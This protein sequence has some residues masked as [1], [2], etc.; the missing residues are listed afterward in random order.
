MSVIETIPSV[1]TLEPRAQALG[2]PFIYPLRP[3]VGKN[4]GLPSRIAAAGNYLPRQNGIATF[5]TD[6]CDAISAECGA[7]G[8]ALRMYLQSY[9]S[10]C[11]LSC[12]DVGT[13]GQ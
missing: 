1:Q 13:P 7:A 5:T 8:R 3:F 6:L 10:N 9:I 2:L 11:E 4:A 12:S